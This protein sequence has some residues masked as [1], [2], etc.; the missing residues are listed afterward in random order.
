MGHHA[1]HLCTR[2]CRRR[3]YA[4]RQRTARSMS[5]RA[6]HALAQG[7]GGRW[8]YAERQRTATRMCRHLCAG[9]CRSLVICRA[10]ADSHEAWAA[11]PR[12]HIAPGLLVAG[13]KDGPSD[14]RRPEGWAATPRTYARALVF[15]GHMPSHSRRPEV[16]AAAPGTLSRRV[17]E[18]ACHM[19]SDNGRQPECAGTYA[20]GLG[21]L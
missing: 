16:W 18:V 12:T 17:L 13:H 11:V 2:S 19:S 5:R 4:E 14:S 8:P 1:S 10:T 6:P 20:R 9:S 7:L 3:P 21:G 15:A